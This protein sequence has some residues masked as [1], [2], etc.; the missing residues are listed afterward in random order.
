MKFLPGYKRVFAF[1]GI[2]LLPALA[3]NF[4]GLAP[5]GSESLSAAEMRATLQAQRGALEA[6]PQPET[7]GGASFGPPFAGLQTATAGAPQPAATPEPLPGYYT[8]ITQSGDTLAALALRFASNPAEIISPEALP[9]LEYLPV[10]LPLGIPDNLAQPPYPSA[11]LPDS[12]IV[13]SPST[14]GFDVA[15]Y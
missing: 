8:Y 5:P 3:C 7:S 1:L 9:P 2:L 11:V 10:G 6:T 13:Y 12:E 15:A 14:L 4:P